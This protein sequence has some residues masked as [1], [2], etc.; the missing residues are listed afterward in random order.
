MLTQLA[1]LKARL[2]IDATYL[3]EDDLLTN[4]IKLTSDR[5]ENECNRTFARA[6]GA[7]EEFNGEELEIIVANYPLEAVSAWHLKTNETEGW[8]AQ[9]GVD[10][11]IRRGS[12]L[13]LYARLGT[14]KQIGRVTYT[15]G[16]VL[17]VDTVGSG[18]TALPDEIQFACVEQC[19]YLFQNRN[20]L[21][22]TAI[23]GEGGSVQQFAQIDLLPSVKATLKAYERWL[24]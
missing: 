15:G 5:F 3:V 21:G 16:Y 14:A 9:T 20:R 19:A 24:N 6:V 18:Q 10:Y 1:T 23:T 8:V 7:T 17:P 11:L 12:V 13:S 2:K 22:M 4:F